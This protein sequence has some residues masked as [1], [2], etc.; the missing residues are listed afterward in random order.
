MCWMNGG[1]IQ[2]WLTRNDPGVGR[3]VTLCTSD[4]RRELTPEKH[5]VQ[6]DDALA[7]HALLCKVPT[8]FCLFR[9]GE[10]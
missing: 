3:A 6:A 4:H 2:V 1:N 9:E 10:W 5:S 7:V 8:R